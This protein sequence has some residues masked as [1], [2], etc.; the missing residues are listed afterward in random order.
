MATAATFPTLPEAAAAAEYL[1]RSG[2]LASAAQVNDV[3]KGSSA[4]VEVNQSDL[5]RARA[6][7][8]EFH[9]EKAD[10]QDD[11]EDQTRPDLSA[12][13]PAL[14]PACP[15]CRSILPLDAS[16]ANCPACREPVDVVSLIVAR[17]GP[18]ALDACYEPHDLNLNERELEDLHASCACGYS[19]HGL[20]GTGTCPE[21]GAPYNKIG[22]LFGDRR[23]EQP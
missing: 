9:K 5:E 3:W 10:L 19:L 2:I 1:I 8:D 7:M 15:N 17:H 23:D 12:L 6:L 22:P 21:C 16:L 4:R 13:D 11:W 18:E 14:A 20:P